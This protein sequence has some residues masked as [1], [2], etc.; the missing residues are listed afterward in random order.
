LSGIVHD[1]NSDQ[2]IGGNQ[3]SK[4][5][6][7]NACEIV[8]TEQYANPDE[9]GTVA[10][11]YI[12]WQGNKYAYRQVRWDE[13]Q[14]ESANV[15][16]NRAGGEWDFELLASNFAVD[17]LLAWGFEPV[18]LGID[19][20]PASNGTGEDDRQ[21]ENFPVADLLAPYPYFGGKRAIAGSVW[22]RFGDVQNYVEPFFGS[23]AVLL[24]RPHVSG[25][26]TIND[27]DGFIANFWRAVASCP[28]DVAQHV[29]WPVNENDLFARHLWLV[30]QRATLTERLHSDPEY[31]DA[32]I[33]GWW[34]W[35]CCAWIGT[36]WCDG[37][38]PWI[39][40]GEQ[41]G[42][43]PHLGDPGQGVNRQLPH[44]GNPGQGVN[45]QLPH[46]GNPG[47]GVNR[48]LPH[49]SRPQGINRYID[50]KRDDGTDDQCAAW[51][52]HLAAMMQTLSDRLRR[53]RVAC[54]DWSRVVTGAVTDR[55][56]LTAVFLDPPYAEGAMEYSAGGNDD[57]SISAAV[58][59]WCIENGANPQMRI[60]FCGYEPL[61]M[62]Q[63]WR[64]LRWTAPKGYQNAENA[65]NRRREIIWFSPHCLTEFQI[66]K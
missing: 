24:S 55:H 34:C 52:E 65:A 41:V 59:A 48:K 30:Q 62:P 21:I 50:G 60:A 33:A 35:G 54:G 39:T 45:R 37:D 2:I 16:A 11:G 18:E 4:V 49:L 44:L 58:R 19:G 7:V 26:E 32:K 51:S 27:L 42:K 46:L 63:G 23:G 14:C 17:D 29:D 66:S 22:A 57:A 40:D 36:G 6:D 28:D 12:L 43:L 5:F 3:R 15:I 53:V 56:G 10:L 13:R 38:G 25:I 47:R 9:Q 20:I 31:C 8:L 61:T 1:L 64:G